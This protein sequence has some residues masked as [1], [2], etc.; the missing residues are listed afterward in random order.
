MMRSSLLA[1]CCVFFAA[2]PALAKIQTQSI[3]YDHGEVH[4]QGY[5]AWDDAVKGRRPGVLVV[6]E[7]WGL[8]DYARKRAEQLAALGYVAFAV[9]MY[10]SGKVTNHPDQA[11]QWMRQVQ[12][13][14]KEW[15]DRAMAGLE[16]L[17]AQPLVDDRKIAAIGYCFGGSTVLQM[18]YSG[19]DIQGVVSFHGALP[20]P[21]R[22]QAAKTKAR[23]LIAHGNADPFLSESHIQSFRHA[24]DEA[25][26]DWQMVIYA[27]ARHSFTN[28]GADAV[29]M[30]ALKYDRTADERSWAHMRLFFQELFH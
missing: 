7:W 25:K 17:R 4:L 27:G 22:T 11:G 9:D 6:H 8:N 14:V 16:V 3:P 13:N 29:G 21:D 5:M 19:A 2:H 24:L 18:A 20:I 15:Q 23:M 12:A 30:D 1:F 10:G 28:P 26:L